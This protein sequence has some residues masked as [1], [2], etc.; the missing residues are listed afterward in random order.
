MGSDKQSNKFLAI[1]QLLSFLCLAQICDNSIEVIDIQVM[2]LTNRSPINWK[3]ETNELW[4]KFIWSKCEIKWIQCCDQFDWHKSNTFDH[5]MSEFEKLRKS[6]LKKGEL[7]EDNDF[8][9]IQSSVFYHEK[10][11][12][13]FIWKRPKEISSHPVFLSDSQSNYFNLS[14]GKLG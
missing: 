11:P 8:A 4:I 7:Y 6:L 13:Q 2:A 12:F 10:A 5:R 3:T 14:P 9:C 1:K